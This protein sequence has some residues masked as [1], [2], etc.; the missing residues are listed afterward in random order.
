M[1]LA[2]VVPRP[3]ETLEAQELA[4]YCRR[5]LADYKVPKSFVWADSLPMTTSGKVQKRVLRE[6]LAASAAATGQGEGS[7]REAAR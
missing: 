2:V 1:V 6:R 3:G 4:A 5:S 7:A